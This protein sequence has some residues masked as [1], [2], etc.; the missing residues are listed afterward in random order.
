MSIK[1]PS[2]WDEY[3]KHILGNKWKEDIYFTAE[4]YRHCEEGSC[5]IWKPSTGLKSIKLI[6]KLDTFDQLNN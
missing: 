4:W 2:K 6:K 5:V 1:G 3:I